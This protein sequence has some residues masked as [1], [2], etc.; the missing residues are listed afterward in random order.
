MGCSDV[1]KGCSGDVHAEQSVLAIEFRRNILYTALRTVIS[2]EL[3]VVDGN[4]D[5]EWLQMS[6]MIMTYLRDLVESR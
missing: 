2:M 3:L 5:A 6:K 4:P 1:G